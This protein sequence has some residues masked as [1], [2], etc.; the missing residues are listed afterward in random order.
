MSNALT[1]AQ[2]NAV[3][4]MGA[5]PFGTQGS[6]GA[7]G[8]TY[9]KFT[10]STGNFTAGSDAEEIEHGTQFALDMMNARYQWSFWWNEEV[11]ATEEALLVERPSLYD[12]EPADLPDDPD[13]KI[14]M[15][16][17]D[18]R[19]MRDDRQNNFMDGWSCQAIITMRAIDGSDEEYTLKLNAGVAMNAFHA[20]RKSFARQ[21]KLKAG[22]IPIVELSANKFKA[23]AKGVGW[24][25]APV[26]RI[27]DWA[28]EEDLM[29]M[30]GDDA[31][32]YDDEPADGAA[33]VE[34]QTS[35]AP[36]DDAP[37]E[38]KPTSRRRGARGKRF[39]A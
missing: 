15:T 3:S 33:Q 6:E 20:L 19:A 27:V 17:E 31:S 14:D 13:S 11:L 24:R 9:M 22:L 26:I 2:D 18:I 1:T 36:A 8:S 25:F 10:G 37:A 29:A 5:D 39:G 16:M 7:Q 32:G 23:K 34:D 35:D 21:Y 4:T 12:E 28:S 30:G 38:E